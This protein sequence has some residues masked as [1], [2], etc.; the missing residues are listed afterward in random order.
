MNWLEGRKTDVWL[1]KLTFLKGSKCALG[2]S[3]GLGYEATELAV[4]GQM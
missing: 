2:S 3:L 4:N 1:V